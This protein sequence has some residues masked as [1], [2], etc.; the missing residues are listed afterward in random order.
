MKFH[1]ESPSKERDERRV[2]SGDWINQLI[3][4][5]PYILVIRGRND[6][7][8]FDSTHSLTQSLISRVRERIRAAE[9]DKS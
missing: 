5:I 8:K 9:Q 1:V 6:V 2:K 3:K 4:Q 7:M